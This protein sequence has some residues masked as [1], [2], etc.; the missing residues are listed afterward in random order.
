MHATLLDDEER[1]H[2]HATT[3]RELIE[4]ATGA[5]LIDTPGMRE[6]Q[7][8]SADDGLAS[9]FADLSVLAQDCRFRDC[10]HESE[11]GCAVRAAVERGTL[12]EDRLASRHQLR[13]ELAYLERRQ[14]IAAATAAR[15][16]AGSMV[17][18]LKGRLREKYD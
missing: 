7:L 13:R 12:A 3:H 8:W 14:D 2:A 16:Y 11:P 10:V 1:Q 17:R 4:L 5:S 6:L 18:A 9:A 15:N